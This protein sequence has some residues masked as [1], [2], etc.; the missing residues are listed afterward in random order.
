MRGEKHDIRRLWRRWITMALGGVGM[1]LGVGGASAEPLSLDDFL[2]RVVER[3]GEVAASAAR[4]RAA[5]AAAE[6]V[7]ASQRPTVALR[8]EGARI[9]REQEGAA[10]LYFSVQAPVDLWGRFDRICQQALLAYDLRAAR[11]GELVN[12]LL[13]SA[14]SLY[15]RAVLARADVVLYESLVRQREEDFRVAKKR[16]EV[17]SVAKL[18]VIRAEV[19]LE[20]TRGELTSARTAYADYLVSLK[21]LAGGTPVEPLSGD[22]A[23]P[24]RGLSE[25]VT[26]WLD[27]RPDLVA[28]E[29]SRA[30]ARGEKELAAL[31]MRPE[32]SA[33]LGYT[34]ATD[35]DRSTP[36][37]H[38]GALTLVVTVPLSDGGQTRSL[39]R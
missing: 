33:S 39:T 6:A 20:S 19:Q 34:L 27:R 16:H 30:L 25:D 8:G 24:T 4:L 35:S 38:D 7:A 17:G 26:F 28:L 37:E 14:E 31:G 22:L 21:A 11:H 3:H 18:D 2:V 9:F 29:V 10:S 13:T 5:R 32:I 36:P 1:I 23:I 12:T 15:W